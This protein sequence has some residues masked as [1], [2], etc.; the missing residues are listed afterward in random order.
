MESI[1]EGAL[2][3]LKTEPNGAAGITMVLGGGT[4]EPFSPSLANHPFGLPLLHATSAMSGYPFRQC[5][6]RPSVDLRVYIDQREAHYSVAVSR[7]TGMALLS[8]MIDPSEG[9]GSCSAATPEE[10][11]DGLQQ[12]LARF[13]AEGISL[14]L[15]SCAYRTDKFAQ[16]EFSA[17]REIKAKSEPRRWRDCLRPV[18]DAEMSAFANEVVSKAFDWGAGNSVADSL[19]L[20]FYADGQSGAVY[21]TITAK[22]DGSFGLATEDR[23]CWPWRKKNKSFRS[24]DDVRAAIANHLAGTHA[25]K[26]KAMNVYFNHTQRL[27]A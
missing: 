23:I 4:P 21:F 18:V 2:K 8:T 10:A 13:A 11:V 17:D 14:Q 5:E 1:L 7:I 3:L 27:A 25:F 15:I 20:W 6:M 12:I 19:S 24:Q 9:V 26:L 16:R 22:N